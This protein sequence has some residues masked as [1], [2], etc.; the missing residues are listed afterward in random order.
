VAVPHDLPPV[1]ADPVLLDA[2]LGN[3]V[4]NVARHA[5]PPA[6]LAIGGRAT[7]DGGLVLEVDDGGPGLADAARARLFTKFQAPLGR[8]AGSRRGLG[9]GLAIVRGM[10]EA[11][12]GSVSGEPSPLGGLR[13]V[14]RLPAATGVPEEPAREPESGRGGSATSDGPGQDRGWAAATTP[15]TTDGPTPPARPAARPRPR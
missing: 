3:I 11:M 8:P 10:A 1:R 13:I 4:E 9:L 15:T 6:A 7:D 12:G 5:P 14:V 2:I